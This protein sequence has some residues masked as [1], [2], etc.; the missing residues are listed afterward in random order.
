DDRDLFVEEN[1][2]SPEKGLSV[3]GCGVDL[4]YYAPMP[5]A[6]G[7]DHPLTFTFIG[8]LLYDKGIK[9]FIQAASIVKARQPELRFW[10]VGEIDRDNPSAIREDDLLRW[11]RDE[12]VQ[13]HGSAEDVRPLIGQS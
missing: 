12:T 2:L 1:I 8:R 11:V 4:E 7:A 9:E 13:Y 5:A 3:N 6:N 10:I